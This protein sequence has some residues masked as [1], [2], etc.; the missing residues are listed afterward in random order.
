MDQELH[1]IRLGEELR[2]RGDFVRPDLHLQAI[3]L[4]LLLALPELIDPPQRIRRGE[5]RR[6]QRSQE[7]LQ[8]E[9]MLGGK[10]HLKQRVVRPEDLRQHPLGAAGRED[11][12]IHT[13]ILGQF[14]GF[15]QADGHVLFRLDEEVVFGQKPGKKHPVPVLVGALAG[16]VINFVVFATGVRFGQLSIAKLPCSRAQMVAQFALGRFHMRVRLIM[17]DRQ[18]FQSRPRADLSRVSGLDDHVLP[19]VP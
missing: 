9:H 8:L 7:S 14:L 6:R 18:G 11:P 4:I 12:Y 15:S 5:D 19:F 13:V 16:Q 2:H 10:G 3:D 1:H 17:V